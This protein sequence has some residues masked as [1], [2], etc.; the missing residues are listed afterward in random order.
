MFIFESFLHKS[1]QLSR[2]KD[3]EIFRKIGISIF[4]LFVSLIF[5]H[6]D[7]CPIFQRELTI[8]LVGTIN[9]LQVKE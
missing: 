1:L 2:H 8:G 9:C 3:A 5:D 7:G 4:C 6:Q